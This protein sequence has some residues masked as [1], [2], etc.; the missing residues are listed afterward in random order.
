MEEL[1]WNHITKAHKFMEDIVTAALEGKSMILSLPVNVPWRNTLLELV[2][3]QLKLENPKNSFEVI[4]CPREE[5]GLFL[6]NKYCKKEMR[7]SYRC[8]LTYAE[9]LGRCEDTVLNDR[10]VWVTDI[11]ETKYEEWL[12]FIVTYQKNV[13][14]KTPAVFV[15][16]T[17][18]VS[19]A[20]RAKKGIKKMI[21]DQNI[22]AYDKFA[23][24]ALVATE[25]NGRDYMRPY[26]A[27]LAATICSEDI[28]L[29]AECV[30]MGNTFIEEPSNTIRNISK[31][32]CRSNGE[33]YQF[34]KTDEEIRRLVW[35]TQLKSVFPVIERFRGCFIKKYYEQIKKVLPISNS[36]GENVT[37]PEDVE[38]GTLFYMVGCS[39]L[40]VSSLEYGE[41]ERYKDARN[42]L[43]HLD[44]LELEV[45]DSILKRDHLL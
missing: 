15:L 23:F 44:I 35:E 18:D 24:C 40:S 2:E 11:P 37:I 4:K 38:I 14:K 17:N 22:G 7:A 42:K 43:A 28:E 19:F 9:F 1:W 32:K 39:A 26:L 34:S 25:N 20:K 6:L 30:R 45:V 3:G 8:G 10:Y 12:E 16:E 31:E 5:A 29:C 21:F 41:L 13:T 27:E 36:C 33:A